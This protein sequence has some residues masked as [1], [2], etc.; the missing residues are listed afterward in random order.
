MRICLNGKDK[1]FY[2]VHGLYCEEINEPLIQI[3]Q[4]LENHRDEFVILDCQHFYD[5]SENDYTILANEML[6]IFQNNVYGQNH[7]NLVDLTLEKAKAQKTQVLIIYRSSQCV[8]SQFWP[9][10]CWPTPW[11]NQIKI[12]KLEKYLD[13]S[14][15][16]RSPECGFVT[17]CVITPP[18][19]FIV[20]R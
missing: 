5:F 6:K 18:V 8:Q 9:S 7:G 20:P 12:P 2:F 16:N 14:L 1:K 3:Q 11:P 4:F 17:Q 15:A 13:L 19:D 10:D